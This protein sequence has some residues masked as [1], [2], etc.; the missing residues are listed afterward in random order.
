MRDILFRGK[1][2]ET[3]EWEYG[4][5]YYYMG[6]VRIV[7]YINDN[8]GNVIDCHHDVDPETVGQYIGKRD[9]KNDKIFE[10][11]IVKVYGQRGVI[12]QIE[13]LEK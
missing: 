3:S 11:D 8:I 5:M 12:K 7:N 1:S 9:C 4:G 13:E 6:F 2:K 10:N